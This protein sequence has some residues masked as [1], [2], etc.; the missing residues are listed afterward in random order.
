M[1]RATSSPLGDAAGAL[2][3]ASKD[4]SAMRI[5][6]SIND[7]L[8]GPG[9]LRCGTIYDGAVVALLLYTLL[10]SSEALAGDGSPISDAAFKLDA[11][12]APPAISF[13][14]VTTLPRLSVEQ[15]LAV[16][17]FSATEFRPRPRSSMESDPAK[18]AGLSMDAPL[19]GDSLSQQM[20]EYRSEDRLRLLTLFEK[21]GSTLSLQAG[22]RGGPSLQWSSPWVSREGASHGLFDRWLSAPARSNTPAHTGPV[23]PASVTATLRSLDLGPPAAA[24]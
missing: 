21:R 4:R 7:T 6:A 8:V 5:L 3:V 13:T 9:A 16:P 14:S 2:V 20:R 22:K 12:A 19:H 15:L 17:S 10:R 23:R 11:A 18:T 1:S 24:K